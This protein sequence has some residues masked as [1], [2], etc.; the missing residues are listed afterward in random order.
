MRLSWLGIERRHWTLI[1]FYLASLGI[2][3]CGKGQ[4][5]VKGKV[6]VGDK[7]VPFGQITFIVP[8]Q[9]PQHATIKD[10]SYE[11]P[12]VP[13][14]TA[15]VVV[16]CPKPRPVDPSRSMDPGGPKMPDQQRKKIEEYQ[17]RNQAAEQELEKWVEIPKKYTS[18]D[19]TP[20]TFEVKAG[21]NE[22]PI[23]ME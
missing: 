15:K 7:P 19:T 22:F 6:L 14:G 23:K 5:T 10:G 21:E 13:A 16:Q 12:G 17:K 9:Q 11:A 3:G 18:V 1:V 2:F 8:D 4:G 20:L